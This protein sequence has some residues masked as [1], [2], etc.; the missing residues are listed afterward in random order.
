MPFVPIAWFAHRCTFCLLCP[1]LKIAPE[2]TSQ[3]Y[4][5]QTYFYAILYLLGKHPKRKEQMERSEAI[6]KT[7]E[8]LNDYKNLVSKFWDLYEAIDQET[9]DLLNE[10][11]AEKW[12]KYAFTLSL[13]ELWFEAGN[14]EIT[15]EDLKEKA[16]K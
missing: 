2:E 4:D 12:F 10:I 9:E 6:E 1:Q 11:G 5:R 16:V 14:W 13:D 8:I 7:N 15:E 3:T